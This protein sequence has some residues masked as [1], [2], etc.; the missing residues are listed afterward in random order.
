MANK[1]NVRIILRIKSKTLRRAV[2]LISLAN[3]IT[4]CSQ[5]RA[6]RPAKVRKLRSARARK[7]LKRSR[8]RLLNHVMKKKQNA[9]KKKNK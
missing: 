3:V 4:E 2:M 5:S 9:L 7:L 8:R 1:K 6:K